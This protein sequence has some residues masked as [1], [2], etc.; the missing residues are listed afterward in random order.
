MAHALPLIGYFPKQTA[1]PRAWDHAPHVTSICSISTC[2]GSA[3]EG[4]MERWIHNDWGYFASVDDARSTIPQGA[5]DF[6]L[7]AYRLFPRR[8]IHHETEPIELELPPIEPLPPAFH[9]IGFDVV[10]R[11]YSAFFECSPLSCNGLAIQIPVNM[12]CLL[13]TLDQ[14]AALAQRFAIE[15]PEPGSYYVIEVLRESSPASAATSPPS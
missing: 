6:T 1:V 8:F 15:Q 11:S 7:F 12:F 4:W 13:D 10:S 14:A 2:I 3:P 5:R 9:S